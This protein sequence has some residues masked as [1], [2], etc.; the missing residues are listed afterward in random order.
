MYNASS[1]LVLLLDEIDGKNY[2]AW[3]AL[4]KSPCVT[5][6]EILS[7][8]GLDP[9]RSPLELWA[10]KTG[11]K[12]PVEQNDFMWL[13]HQ[14]EPII[15]ELFTRRTG[16]PLLRQ[17]SI[18]RHSEFEWATA[19]PDNFWL[20]SSG[21]PAGIVECK[22]TSHWNE[23][24][25]GDTYAPDAAVMQL[26]WQAGVTG[27]VHNESYIAGLVGGNPTM[28]YHP[29]FRFSPDLF[30]QCLSMA[31]KFLWFVR[32]DTPP[33]VMARDRDALLEILPAP[34]DTIQK[35]LSVKDVGALLEEYDLAVNS[36]LDLESEIKFWKDKEQ[37]AKN[38]IEQQMGDASLATLPDGRYAV[39]RTVQWKQ[40][41]YPAKTSV[42]FS[43]R[44][45]RPK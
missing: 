44:K 22:N 31:D 42:D 36:R 10:Y 32:N 11:R 9:Y 12:P 40:K 14:M 6:S 21:A 28:F 34:V 38:R 4:H 45:S 8:C 41:V 37:T 25:W 27:L 29:L 7:V 17:K 1:G 5:S 43:I 30:S 39:R 15:S 16:L 23:F 3:L 2:D 13:G 26:N 19:S 20:D 33:Q 35:D 18:Y 24:K